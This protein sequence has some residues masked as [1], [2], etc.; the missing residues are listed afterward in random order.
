MVIFLLFSVRCTAE[1]AAI[2]KRKSLVEELL[3]SIY[4]RHGC[5]RYRGRASRGHCEVSRTVGGNLRLP[6]RSPSVNM[7]VTGND[8]GGNRWISNTFIAEIDDANTGNIVNVNDSVNI[9]D[10]LGNQ[11][12]QESN[13][14]ST[15]PNSVASD[16]SDICDCNWCLNRAPSTSSWLADDSEDAGTL[17]EYS[18]TSDFDRGRRSASEAISMRPK[19]KQKLWNNSRLWCTYASFIYFSYCFHNS[20][21]ILIIH[22]L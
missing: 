9:D 7:P 20:K 10:D 1:S 13:V 6:H 16:I 5:Q 21:Y 8:N 3:G 2:A 14:Q 11:W 19:R 18:T 17:T 22:T 15:S 4:P 12:P